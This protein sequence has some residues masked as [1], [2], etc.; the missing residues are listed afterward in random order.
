MNNEDIEKILYR[1]ELSLASTSKRASAFFFDELLLSLL[2]IV[3][4]WGNFSNLSSAVELISLT[5]QFTLEYIVLKIIYQ[6][7]FTFQYGATLG[8]LLM[9]VRVISLA[10]L[11]NPS[12]QTSFNRSVFR[13]ISEM[14]FYL[15][16]IWGI[17]D[18]LNR[19]WHDL[20][21]KTIVIES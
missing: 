5:Q 4:L 16:F 11:S 19:T 6:T 15:G 3:S 8:K 14:L 10:T 13:I 20:T 9:K 21:A 12:L 2:L 1:E 17:T 18:P 7:Y